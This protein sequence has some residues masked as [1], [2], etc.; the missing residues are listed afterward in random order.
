M[1]VDEFFGNEYSFILMY[2]EDKGEY[3]LYFLLKNEEE[4]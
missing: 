2:G 4:D 3:M 1:F